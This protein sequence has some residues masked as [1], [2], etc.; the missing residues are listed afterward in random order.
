MVKDRKDDL[1]IL[2]ERESQIKELVNAHTWEIKQDFRDHLNRNI[3]QACLEAGLPPVETDRA[4]ITNTIKDQ[5]QQN[6]EDL[7]IC[8]RIGYALSQYT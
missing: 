4:G 8:S 2:M 7:A 5:K 3:K 6:E 1:E